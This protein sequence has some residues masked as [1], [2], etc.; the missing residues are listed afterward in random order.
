MHGIGLRHW[1]G[2][3]LLHAALIAGLLWMQWSLQILPHKPATVEWDVSL[4]EPAPPAAPPAP[5]VREQALVKPPREIPKPVTHVAPTPPPAA[6]TPPQPVREAPPQGIT[7]PRM[8]APAP[9]VSA[10]RPQPVVQLPYADGAWIGQTLTGV[11]NARK[12][13]PLQARRMGVEGKVV[14]EAVVNEQGRV[15]E[16]KIKSSSGSPILD[17]DALALLRSVPDLKP[18][19]MKLAARTV[20]QIPVNYVLEQ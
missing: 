10:P 4:V 6:E 16:A 3:T 15:V 12:R 11:M 20:V 13:Y 17:Q 5:P 7:P 8:E 1:T 19:K 14:I 9:V 18:D 2:S